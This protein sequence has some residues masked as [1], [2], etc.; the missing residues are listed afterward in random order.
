M[1]MQ[2]RGFMLRARQRPTPSRQSVVIGLLCVLSCLCALAR[3]AAIERYLWDQ[4]GRVL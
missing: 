3:V 1:I 2:T 4:E